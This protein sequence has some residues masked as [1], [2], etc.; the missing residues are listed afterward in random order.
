[1][2][3]VCDTM[4]KFSK[5]K[6][7]TESLEYITHDVPYICYN[8]SRCQG[9]CYICR[10]SVESISDK[11]HIYINENKIFK[12]YRK[13]FLTQHINFKLYLFQ[14]IKVNTFHHDPLI[15]II[16]SYIVPSNEILKSIVNDANTYS[17]ISIDVV[18]N[19]FCNHRYNNNICGYKNTCNNFRKETSY[20]CKGCKN[21]YGLNTKKEMKRREK[22]QLNYEINHLDYVMYGLKYR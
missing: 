16:V 17:H 1:M 14:I 10:Q 18:W 5:D 22:K 8:T 4:Q 19:I 15:Q 7:L 3:R 6:S 9:K 2:S 12:Y 11:Y 20:W 13:Y 21:K